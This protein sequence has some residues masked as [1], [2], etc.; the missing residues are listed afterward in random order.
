[1]TPA[2]SPALSCYRIVADIN[3]EHGIHLVQHQ[4][5][6]KFYVRKTLGVYSLAVFQYLAEHPLPGI[7]R[8]YE[9]VEEDSRLILI[10][11]YIPGATLQ[12]LLDADGPLSQAQVVDYMVQLCTVLHSLHSCEPPIV[13]RDI[14]P[15]NI[16][17]TPDGILKLID[18]NAARCADG[19]AGKDTVLLGTPGFAAPEQYGFGSS[20]AQTDIFALGVLMNLLPTGQLSNECTATGPLAPAIRKCVMM[21]RTRRYSSALE[22]RKAL[23]KLQ[24]RPH[25]P[26]ETDDWM[27]YLPPG[28]RKGNLLSMLLGT[29]GYAMLFWVCLTME[30]ENVPVSMQQLQRVAML[31]SFLAAIF[32]SADYRHI[33]S[34]IP[35]C[36]SKK[37]VVRLLGILLVD[38]LFFFL[39]IVVLAIY[40]TV[41][42]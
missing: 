29:I 26:I 7:P 3:S 14:K 21:E 33:Q 35:L 5:T 9:T 41:F 37:P 40:E 19:S 13:H 25:R 27:S 39:C 10:E 15:S 4:E 36:R 20:D 30:T 1:M 34:S 16:V 17:I 28:F 23:K 12:E 6:G 11:E 8:I 38:A 31:L 32:F 24:K 18:L 42:A 22:V 2:A